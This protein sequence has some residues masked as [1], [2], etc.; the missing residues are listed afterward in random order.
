MQGPLLTIPRTVLW[1]KS[2]AAPETPFSGAILDCLIH[3]TFDIFAETY[4]A[5]RAA[6]A[7]SGR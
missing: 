3:H 7:E 6:R 4:H 5:P 2:S 1:E